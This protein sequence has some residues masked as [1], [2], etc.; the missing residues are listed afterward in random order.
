MC[1]KALPRVRFKRRRA[2]VILLWMPAMGLCQGSHS[3]VLIAAWLSKDCTIITLFLNL[4][5]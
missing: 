1:K 5:T 2:R 4:E 3:D